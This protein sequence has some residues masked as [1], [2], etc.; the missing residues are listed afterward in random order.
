MD[1]RMDGQMDGGWRGGQGDNR[2]E[3]EWMSGWWE[4]ELVQR[5]AERAAVGEGK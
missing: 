5:R 3:R 4:E 2:E 1:G